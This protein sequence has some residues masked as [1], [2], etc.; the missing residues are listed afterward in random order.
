MEYCKIHKD[1]S[2]EEPEGACPLCECLNEKAMALTRWANTYKKQKA[3]IAQLHTLLY[4]Y[5]NLLVDI[6]DD[7]VTVEEIHERANELAADTA[8]LLGTEPGSA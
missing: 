2:D 3:E 7:D 4:R 6:Y 1:L 8:K 5:A